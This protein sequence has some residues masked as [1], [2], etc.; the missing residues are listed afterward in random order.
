MQDVGKDGLD[1]I[2]LTLVL[3]KCEKNRLRI[4]TLEAQ[5]KTL[6]ECLDSFEAAQSMRPTQQ[7]ARVDMDDE[8]LGQQGNDEE[9]DD[10][11]D[12]NMASSNKDDDVEDDN[13]EDE[14]VGP[15]DYDKYWSEEANS[16][17]ESDGIVKETTV[18]MRE[19]DKDKKKKTEME[20]KVHVE[21]GRHEEEMERQEEEM[22]RKNEEME[23]HDEEIKRQDDKTGKNA[24]ISLAI[25][26]EAIQK[27]MLTTLAS[28]MELNIRYEMPSMFLC[29]VIQCH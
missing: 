10:N 29:A 1:D 15:L 6:T 19:D 28:L 12:E 14:N 13:D 17:D 21:M 8:V 18:R 3:G 4:K 9:Y 5:V 26:G 22:R 2:N 20:G 25:A 24:L 23:R 27:S 11:N 7:M 16:G